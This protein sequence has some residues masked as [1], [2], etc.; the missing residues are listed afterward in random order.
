MSLRSQK[1]LPARL[2]TLLLLLFFPLP[3]IWPCLL[4]QSASP[5]SLKI[6]ILD[7]EGAINNIRQRTAREPIVQVEDENRKP[8]AGALVLFTLPN[9]GPGGVFADGTRTSIVYTDAKGQAVARGFQPNQI[10]GKYQIRVDASFQ[11]RTAGTV[12]HQSN[13]SAAAAGASTSAA[14]ISAKTLV[15]LGAVGAAAVAGGIVIATRKND[16]PSPT[17]LTMGDPVVG[18]P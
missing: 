10:A 9:R 17:G 7:G 8:V 14:G 5:A 4:A 12:I 13:V 16:S 18:R 3:G 15:I 6:V 11:G 1:P 2:V